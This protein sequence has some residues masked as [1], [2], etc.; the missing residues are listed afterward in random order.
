MF[1]LQI[2]QQKV[3]DTT[4]DYLER[5]ILEVSTVHPHFATEGIWK[6]QGLAANHYIWKWDAPEAADIKQKLDEILVPIIG[7]YTSTVPTILD[8]QLP[9]AVHNDYI[10]GGPKSNLEP[11]VAVMI[12]LETVPTRTVFFDQHA[13]Y[14]DFARYKEN[15]GPISDHVHHVLWKEV[16]S[17]CLEV[18]RYYL[19]IE[20]IYEWQRGDLVIFDRRQW[21]ASDDYR[22]KLKSKRAIIIFT[23]KV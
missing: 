2:F 21:H 14:K 10:L 7:N 6:D 18:D 17:H 1:P 20:K 4:L 11:Y 16:L 22:S 15:H 5:R 9:W 13:D 23:D 8:S 12:P 3:D 19:S